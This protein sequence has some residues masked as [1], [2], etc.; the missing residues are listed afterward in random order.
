[1]KQMQF[2]LV[3]QSAVVGPERVRFDI[4]EFVDNINHAHLNEFRFNVT[5]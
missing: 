1:M 5:I 4:M 2:L 3:Q